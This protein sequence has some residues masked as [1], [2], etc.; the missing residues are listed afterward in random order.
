[1]SDLFYAPPEAEV[2]V[3]AVDEPAFYVVAPRK[4]FLLAVLTLNLYFIYWFYRSWRA[5]KEQSGESIWPPVRGLLYIFFTHSLFAR[6]D[7][8][9]KS[10]GKQFDW[11]P[12]GTATIVVVITIVRQ[13]L[14]RV[15][16]DQGIGVAITVTLIAM[17]LIFALPVVMLKAQNAA[18][19]ASNDEIGSG[20][21]AL[22]VGNW[23]WMIIGGLVWL[24]AMFGL[25]MMMTTPELFME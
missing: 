4:F 6:I 11:S 10:D 24:F 2:E 19:L 16:I 15:S 12:S 5:V 18:N 9:I 17:G 7:D 1:M 13:V 21:S 14:D 20:N 22:T 23:V 25:Y 3:Q 8:K